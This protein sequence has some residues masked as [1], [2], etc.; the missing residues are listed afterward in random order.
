MDK[1][2][3]EKVVSYFM[4]REEKYLLGLK[5]AARERSSPTDTFISQE[6]T[7]T[8]IILMKVWH[9]NYLYILLKEH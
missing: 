2:W 1:S 3:L 7:H 5:N 6:V 4:R 8:K 9:K